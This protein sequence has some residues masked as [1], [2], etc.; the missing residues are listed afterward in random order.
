MAAN[1]IIEGIR[2]AIQLMRDTTDYDDAG[3]IKEF[4]SFGFSA[5]EI[6]IA[7]QLMREGN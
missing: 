1:E 5:D 2:E 7:K 4:K 6:K 3:I